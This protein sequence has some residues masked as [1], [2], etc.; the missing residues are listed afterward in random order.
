MSFWVVISLSFL[1][2]F[3][4]LKQLVDR[5]EEQCAAVAV[6][7]AVVGGERGLHGGGYADSAVDGATRCAGLPNPTSATCGG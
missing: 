4:L 1:Q 3:G 6:A 2:E 5:G 7:G